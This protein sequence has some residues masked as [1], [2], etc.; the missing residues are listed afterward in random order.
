MGVDLINERLA[1]FSSQL[2][3]SQKVLI[4]DD[5]Q[6]ILKMIEVFLASRNI[7]SESIDSAEG[8]RALLDDGGFAVVLLDK[9]LPGMSGIDLLKRIKTDWSKIEVIM[10]TAHASVQSA[11]E[12]IELGAF[13]YI[14][15]PIPSLT[16]LV[17]KTRGALARHDFEVR[18]NAM[19]RFLSTTIQEVLLEAEAG[20]QAV[21]ARRLMELLTTCRDSKENG[22]VL[23]VGPNDMALQIAELGLETVPLDSL[24]AAEAILQQRD[25][26]VHVVVVVEH[27]GS[28]TTGDAI[29]RLHTIDP[30]VGVFVIANNEDLAQIVRAIGAGMGDY[31]VRP[32]EGQE[33]LGPRLRRLVTRQQRVARYRNLLESL[34]RLNVDLH[35][36]SE[37]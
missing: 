31:L 34:K 14:P 20:D 5:D 35:A 16:Y 17:E 13:D 29:L 27:D 33:L 9:N 30:D 21:A 32:F 6:A 24:Q 23:V 25:R 1:E 10:I 18:V 7:Q 11:L 2:H 15:K 28:P 3:V 22:H 36:R 26:D 8:A 12:S 37:S 19:I 4:V